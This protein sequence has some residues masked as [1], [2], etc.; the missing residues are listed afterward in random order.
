MSPA[1]VGLCRGD[2]NRITP[3]TW[4]LGNLPH[5]NDITAT[6]RSGRQVRQLRLHQHQGVVGVQ[7][8][9]LHDPFQTVDRLVTDPGLVG[10][11]LLDRFGIGEIACRN[12]HHAATVV[13][14]QHEIAAV[15]LIDDHVKR[16]VLVAQFGDRHHLELCFLATIGPAGSSPAECRC[17]PPEG[18]VCRR[19]HRG[20]RSARATASRTCVR[21]VVDL[22]ARAGVG[23]VEGEGQ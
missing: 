9:Q 4:P 15:F 23:F 6:A 16:P 5:D 17:T 10:H 21:A 18:A 20:R 22:N 14:H 7:A 12:L 2:T 8:V 11:P 13:G 1:T 3:D 19:L